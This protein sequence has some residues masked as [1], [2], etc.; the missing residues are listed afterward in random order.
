MR[1]SDGIFKL[2]NL[3]RRHFPTRLQS[4]DPQSGQVLPLRLWPEPKRLI[5]QRTRGGGLRHI[6]NYGIWESQVPKNR[7]SAYNFFRRHWDWWKRYL[8][9]ARSLSVF[10]SIFFQ[11]LMRCFEFCAQS[12]N[13]GPTRMLSL[14]RTAVFFSRVLVGCGTCR[15]LIQ[16]LSFSR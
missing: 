5:E 10:S 2:R 1:C 16:L 3:F 9:A 14:Y 8:L 7:Q 6:T 4:P 12:L 15:R 11:H 13:S